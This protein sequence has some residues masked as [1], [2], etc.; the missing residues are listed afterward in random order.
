MPD[1]LLQHSP[2]QLAA[3]VKANT[4]KATDRTGRRGRHSKHRPIKQVGGRPLDASLPCSCG[5]R[6]SGL[7]GYSAHLPRRR[8]LPIA[9][10]TQLVQPSQTA[11]YVAGVMQ[12]MTT[13]SAVPGFLPLPQAHAT[14]TVL[15]DDGTDLSEFLVADIGQHS[16][17]LWFQTR[18]RQ[19]QQQRQQQR[20]GWDWQQKTMGRGRACRADQEASADLLQPHALAAVAVCGRAAADTVRGDAVARG[21][22]VA[23]AAVCE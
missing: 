7:F 20:R 14:R 9:H 3:P 8:Q 19:Q 11:I 2:Q 18:R 12:P 16:T 22:G 17:R 5:F 6:A 1:W 23:Q 4:S 21:A 13:A 15:D 10:I